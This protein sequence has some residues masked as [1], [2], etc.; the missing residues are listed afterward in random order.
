MVKTE[1][2]SIKIFLQLRRDIKGNGTVLCSPTTAG[3]WQGMTY[4]G[5]QATGKTGGGS[6][7]YVVKEFLGNRR[8]QKFEELVKNLCENY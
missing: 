5:I 1:K 6:F 7:K 3:L 4:H 8:A 2:V